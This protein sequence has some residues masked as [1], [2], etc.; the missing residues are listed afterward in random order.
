MTVPR[1]KAA[2][3]TAPDQPYIHPLCIAFTFAASV[4]AKYKPFSMCFVGMVA[5]NDSHYGQ[6]KSVSKAAFLPFR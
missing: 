1:K 3:K 5:A 4:F 6:R 2:I